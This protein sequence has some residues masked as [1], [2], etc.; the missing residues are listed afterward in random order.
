MLVEFVALVNRAYYAIRISVREAG[1]AL[2]R[3][4]PTRYALMLCL[5]FL[6]RHDNV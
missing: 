3:A 2:T 6:G 5:T 4:L 1:T